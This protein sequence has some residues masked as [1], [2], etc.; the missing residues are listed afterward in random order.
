MI[1][2][3]SGQRYIVYL[4]EAD[5]SQPVGTVV[6]AILWDGIAA[7]TLPSGRALHLDAACQY[8][9]GGEYAP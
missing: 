1:K 7:L 3:P 9:I 4:T 2:P 6:D 5:G 8:P